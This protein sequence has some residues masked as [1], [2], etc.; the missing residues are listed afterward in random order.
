[1]YNEVKAIIIDDGNNLIKNEVVFEVACFDSS[2]YLE[3]AFS[4][5]SLATSVAF[6]GPFARVSAKV[7]LQCRG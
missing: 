2:I 7:N 1:M 6:E 5:E 4:R 3:V